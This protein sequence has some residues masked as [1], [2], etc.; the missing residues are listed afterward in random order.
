M[1]RFIYL[2]FCDRGATGTSRH[3]PCKVHRIDLAQVVSKLYFLHS[4]ALFYTLI[5]T[6]TRRRK[7]FIWPV[8]Y[9]V[10][11]A[12][13]QYL[14]K[15]LA[16]AITTDAGGCKSSHT[17]RNNTEG[18]VHGGKS[19]PVQANGLRPPHFLS[20]VYMLNAIFLSYGRLIGLV[21]GCI[22]KKRG[23]RMER[24]VMSHRLSGGSVHHT[25]LLSA[26]VTSF[27]NQ[28]AWI[29]TSTTHWH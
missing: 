21:F 3:L 6:I 18:L 23:R 8:K 14:L 17:G 26:I 9:T 5:S 27:Q 15:L 7:S 28:Q 12:T 2:L 1:S 11:R 24:M 25:G 13:L 20:F 4:Q 16:V 22:L 19:W 10:C 29:T